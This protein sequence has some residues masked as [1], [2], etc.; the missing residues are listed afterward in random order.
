[1]MKEKIIDHVKKLFDE[2]K[3]DGF[4]GLRQCN[5]HIAPHLFTGAGDL[6]DLSLGDA[7]K[8]GDARYPLNSILIMLSKAYPE[9]TFGVLVRGCD[10][11]G[12]IELTKWNQVREEK[13]LAVGIACPED[14]AARCSCAKPYPEQ[15]VAG[16]KVEGK[17]QS[18]P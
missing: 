2:G 12:L 18:G 6:Q 3:I 14:L 16:E 4:I 10:E 7:E 9:A 1:M 5:G 15:P 11:R 8:P 17:P 13:V